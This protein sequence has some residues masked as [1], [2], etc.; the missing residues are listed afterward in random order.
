MV[1]SYNSVNTLYN[2]AADVSVQQIIIEQDGWIQGFSKTSSTPGT[3]FVRLRI[4]N[5]DVWEAGTSDMMKIPYQEEVQGMKME[6][7]DRVMQ[8]MMD[9]LDEKQLQEL[10][11]AL[12]ISLE[13]LTV[14]REKTELSTEVID[15]W[16]YVRRFLQA[17]LKIGRAHV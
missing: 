12:V 16:E 5:V 1:P 7:V 11:M 2:S 17:F 10:R 14:E 15:N 8:R 9:I 6:L 13:G 3:P 4:N